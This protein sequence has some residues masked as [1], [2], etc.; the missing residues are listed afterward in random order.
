MR[1]SLF[2]VLFLSLTLPTAAQS[3]PAEWKAIKDTKGACQ[4]LIPPDWTPFGEAGGSAVF[5]DPS[6][7]IA[8][9]TSQPGQTFKP[10]T[11]AQLKTLGVPRQDVFEDSEKRLFYQDRKSHGT[12]DP[13]AFSA[14]VPAKDGACSCHIVFVP[15]VGDETARKI[16]LSLGPAPPGKT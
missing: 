3:V 16:A 8:V 14:M 9:V 6:T 12:D 4:I 7:A 11:E 13:S 10:L 2:A 15:G 1:D 5:H